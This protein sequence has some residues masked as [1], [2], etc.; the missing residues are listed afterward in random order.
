MFVNLIVFII[1]VTILGCTSDCFHRYLFQYNTYTLVCRYF[2]F[3]QSL[4]FDKKNPIKFFIY[5]NVCILPHKSREITNLLSCDYVTDPKLM[6]L[7]K[8]F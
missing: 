4:S 1:S 5:C 8:S 2:L 3:H 6:A 7:H